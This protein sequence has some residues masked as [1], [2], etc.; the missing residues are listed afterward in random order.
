MELE[1]QSPFTLV[2]NAFIVLIGPEEMLIDSL[3]CSLKKLQR[4]Q[5]LY[6]SG[7]YSRILDKLDRRFTELDVRRAFTAYQLMTILKEA[8]QTQIIFEYDPTLFEDATEMAE[9]VGQALK[10]VSNG[11]SVL[12]YSPWTDRHLEEVSKFADRVFVFNEVHKYVYKRASKKTTPGP[13]GQ[14]TLEAF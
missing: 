1:L 11:S 13:R 6:I 10:E 8:Y 14:R 12:L 5:V 2:P 3:N 4:L 7:N 9:Y